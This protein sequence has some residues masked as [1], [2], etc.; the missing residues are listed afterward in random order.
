M[1]RNKYIIIA[2]IIVVVII[3][4][5]LFWG[6][7]KIMFSKIKGEGSGSGSQSNAGGGGGSGSAGGTGNM[8]VVKSP[9]TPPTSTEPSE[10]KVGNSVVSTMSNKKAYDDSLTTVKRIYAKDDFIGVVMAKKN[11]WFVVI[12]ANGER[13]NISPAGIKKFK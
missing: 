12:S 3:L 8:T 4:L 1:K 11:D 2:V 7:I 13:L 10:I 5:Y 9:D 6:D